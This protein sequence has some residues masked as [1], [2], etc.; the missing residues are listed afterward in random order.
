[1]HNI[2]NGQNSF[3]KK[4]SRMCNKFYLNLFIIH[5]HTHILIY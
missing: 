3:K 2:E 1:M 4:F 5:T